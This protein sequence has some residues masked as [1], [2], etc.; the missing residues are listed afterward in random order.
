MS[1]LIK[2]QVSGKVEDDGGL[3]FLI[4]TH[5]RHFDLSNLNIFVSQISSSNL[6]SVKVL[7]SKKNNWKAC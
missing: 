3:G 5:Y 1:C 2:E 4:F 7:Q 6:Q